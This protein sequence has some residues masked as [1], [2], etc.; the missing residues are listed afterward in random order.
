[1]A[2]GSKKTC[3][4]GIKRRGR[5]FSPGTYGNAAIL[6]SGPV[7]EIRY[8]KRPTRSRS[9]QYVS[10]RPSFHSGSA[11]AM[12]VVFMQS[13]NLMRSNW[14]G[15]CIPELGHSN[16]LLHYYRRYVS[17]GGKRTSVLLISSQIFE[18]ACWKV[19][20]STFGVARSPAPASFEAIVQ[21]GCGIT[22]SLL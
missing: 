12:K 11:Q 16:G 7:R 9:F 19:C 3:L 1:M 4:P 14:S 8:S 17:N 5:K 22:D 2:W 15:L 21:T 6:S 13:T 10:C 18:I 20:V